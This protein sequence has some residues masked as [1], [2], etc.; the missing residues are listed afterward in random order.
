MLED[1][2]KEMIFLKKTRK[3]RRHSL[4]I[5]GIIILLT[6][7]KPDILF[8]TETPTSKDCSA[9]CAMLQNHG[10]Y[11]H[12]PASNNAIIAE[13]IPPEAR[14]PTTL[15]QNGGGCIKK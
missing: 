14:I 7:H 15:T 5:T 8:F 2:V 3:N 11:T 4:S 12:L 6:L 10:Y 13:A 1:P 9:L